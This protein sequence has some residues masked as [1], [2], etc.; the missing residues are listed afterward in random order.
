MMEAAP[1]NEIE[2]FLETYAAAFDDYDGEAIADCFAYPAVLWQFGKGHVFADADEMLENTAALLKVLEDVGVTVSSFEIKTL[3]ISGDTALATVDWYQENDEGEALI[4][5]S[6]HYHLV[7]DGEAWRIAMIV[8]IDED[9]AD[10]PDE[11]D[12]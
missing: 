11:T 9:E 2:A 6:C 8:N 10:A 1:D 5:F 12:G 4:E 7:H 3:A